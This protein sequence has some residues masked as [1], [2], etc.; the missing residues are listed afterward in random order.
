MQRNPVFQW[1]EL[2]SPLALASYA[3]WLAVYLTN[4]GWVGL[5]DG[6][7]G[8]A[9][10]VLMWTFLAAWLV[11]LSLEFGQ[12]RKVA[13]VGIVVLAAC[14]LGLLTLGHSSTGAILLVLLATQLAGRFEGRG[15]LVSLVIVNLVFALIMWQIWNYPPV[16]IVL[17]LASYAA[18]QAFAALVMH[19][20]IKAESMAEELQEANA[21]LLATRSLLGEAARDQERLR[22]SR[23]LHDVAGHKLTA[24]KLNLRQLSRRPELNDC[25]ELETAASLADELLGDL[26]AVVRQLRDHDGIDLGH[27]IRQLI[28]P[29]P[30]PRVKLALE[31]SLRIPGTCQAETLLR[32]VQEG[33]TNAVRHGH[34]RNAWLGLQRN[35]N[36]ILLQLEDD[37][38]LSWPI[39]PGNGLTGMRERLQELGGSLQLEPSSRGGL[40]LTARLPAA[41]VS[42]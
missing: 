19:Y 31:A 36:D 2:L 35:G 16:W 37:G 13:D 9:G 27:G 12:G 14:A 25:Q 42:S 21:H 34:A 18:F 33:L 22:L 24:L 4:S 1:R 30:S 17:T 6:D 38:S 32:I 28:E 41:T 15:L 8:L 11:L 7:S 20:A 23:E 39:Q 10:Q 3:A 26:R 29:L 40:S 5:P